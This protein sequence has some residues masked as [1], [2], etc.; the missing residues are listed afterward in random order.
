MTRGNIESLYNQWS[1]RHRVQI[2]LEQC[3]MIKFNEWLEKQKRTQRGKQNEWKHNINF[4]FDMGINQIYD[5]F[6]FNLTA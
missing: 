1:G 6:S 3:V 5:T 2:V 4:P